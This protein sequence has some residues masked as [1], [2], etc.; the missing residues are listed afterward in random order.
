MSIDIEWIRSC[1]C[2]VAQSCPTLCDPMNC[3]MLG[4]PVLAHL[5]ELVRWVSDAIQPTHPLSPPSP[6]ALNPSQPSGSLPMSWLFPSGGQTE[7]SA[8]VLLMNIQGWFSL[9]LIGFISLQFKEL[10]SLLQHHNSKALVL[11]L[12]YG[13]TLTSIYGYWKKHSLAY[14]NICQQQCLSF[15]I[16]CLGLS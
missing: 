12:L 5:P 10:S 11:N 4:F 16:H 3:S 8:S 13:P 15:F 14:T 7:A 6:L 9:R 2:S 1:G